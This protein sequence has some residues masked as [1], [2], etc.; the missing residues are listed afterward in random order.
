[1]FTVQCVVIE[2]SL[3]KTMKR[4]VK[5]N[6]FFDFIL[7]WQDRWNVNIFVSS[8]TGWRDEVYADEEQ[9]NKWNEFSMNGNATFY[10]LK[11]LVN[12]QIYKNCTLMMD[13]KQSNPSRG[14]M[15]V[16]RRKH[17]K[18]DKKI[19]NNSTDKDT[20]TRNVF[21]L[22]RLLCLSDDMEKR[23]MLSVGFAD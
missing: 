18:D 6:H 17:N 5:E 8:W 14:G 15:V 2:V 20:W 23:I 1:M 16:S 9:T 3:R 10:L 22:Q 4:K 19:N 7:E 12:M 21:N 11:F 13:G